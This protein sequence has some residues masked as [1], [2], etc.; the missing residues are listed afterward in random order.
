MAQSK[1]STGVAGEEVVSC[2]P[3]LSAAPAEVVCEAEESLRGAEDTSE[4]FAQ[5]PRDWAVAVSRGRRFRRT[6]GYAESEESGVERDWE[7]CSIVNDCSSLNHG[8]KV[9]MTCISINAD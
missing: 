4:E 2:P 7:G 5:V 9:N 8:K 6:W 3:L 1:G